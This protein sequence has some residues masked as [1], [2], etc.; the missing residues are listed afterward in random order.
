MDKPPMRRTQARVLERERQR[1][2]RKR[3]DRLKWQIP[4]AALGA[5]VIAAAAYVVFAS[6][7]KSSAAA[8]AGVN[9]PH[10][11]VNTQKLDL[12]DQALGN[13]VHASF[14]VKNTGDGDLTLEVPQMPTVLEGC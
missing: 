11:E 10:L 6:S 12:G 14:D 5:L 13:S 3:N 8:S 9:G 1:A 7:T 2:A 4:V